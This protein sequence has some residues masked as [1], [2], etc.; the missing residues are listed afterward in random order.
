MGENE[1]FRGFYGRLQYALSW[2]SLLD[3]IATLV[4]WIDVLFRSAGCVRC[5]AAAIA[6][7]KFVTPLTYICGT[8]YNSY[9]DDVPSAGA[10]L[11]WYRSR[12]RIKN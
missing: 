1:S 5:A 9:K 11:S 12:S 10:K 6:R 2:A 8:N 7:I 4:L 3:I